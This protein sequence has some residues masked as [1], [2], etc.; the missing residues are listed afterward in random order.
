MKYTVITVQ[1]VPKKLMDVCKDS[2]PPM[3]ITPTGITWVPKK[4]EGFQKVEVQILE[5]MSQYK[6]RLALAHE[7]FHVLQYLTGCEMEEKRSNEIDEI[8]VAALVDKKKVK[9]AQGA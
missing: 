7:L 1:K 6:T 2:N 8:I 3:G 5:K 4:D 9:R